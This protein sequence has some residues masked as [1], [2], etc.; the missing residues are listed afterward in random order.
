MSYKSSKIY[1]LFVGVSLSFE[2][3]LSLSSY[4]DKN[5]EINLYAYNELTNLPKGVVLHDANLIIPRS[6]IQYNNIENFESWFAYSVLYK[7]GGWWVSLDTVCL[8]KLNIDSDYVFT[9]ESDLETNRISISFS[10][11]KIMQG[12]PILKECLNLIGKQGIKGGE[13]GEY[14]RNLLV[15]MIKKYNL[16]EHIIGQKYFN[17]LITDILSGFE[18]SFQLKNVM[19]LSL[20][21][22]KHRATSH[23]EYD[24]IISFL[25]K[26]NK[27]KFAANPNSTTGLRKIKVI[28]LA[29]HTISELSENLTFLIK[30]LKSHLEIDVEVINYNSS[31]KK[32][33]VSLENINM[34]FVESK[35]ADEVI[36]ETIND[37]I[38]SCKHDVVGVWHLG[39]YIGY[40]QIFEAITRIQEFNADLVFPYSNFSYFN[41][42]LWYWMQKTNSIECLW[43]NMDYMKSFKRIYYDSSIYFFNR[44]SYINIGGEN[45]KIYGS[46]LE[47][48]ERILRV[49]KAVL[50]ISRMEKPAY[51]TESI[52]RNLNEYSSVKD[53]QIANLSVLF[54][55]SEFN[56]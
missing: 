4:I 2:Q 28:I 11:I 31:D 20:K 40:S 27:T 12:A 51:I 18:E 45:C 9:T 41:D 53:E 42:I 16:K 24:K 32:F 49:K 1:C 22:I 37:I 35:I 8:N 50:S 5:G 21:S 46:R 47:G 25:S 54:T 14:S 17:P 56:R 43:E 13:K 36:A 15:K 10:I 55:N 52:K 44:K 23:Q 30:Y 7:D 6:Y 48:L 34:H 26:K 33:H 38:N 39:F 29:N 3:V 19:T